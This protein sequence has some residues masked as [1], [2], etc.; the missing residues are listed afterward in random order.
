M[1]I[2]LLQLGLAAT[3]QVL[4]EGL[5][6]GSSCCTGSWLL[7]GAVAVA[8]NMGGIAVSLLLDLCSRRNFVRLHN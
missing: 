4:P 8:V 1:Q 5:F 7:S 3:S 6:F 2:G